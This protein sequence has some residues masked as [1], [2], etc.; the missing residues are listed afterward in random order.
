MSADDL[1][2]FPSGGGDI[3]AHPGSRL[4]FI[5]VLMNR[6]QW[7][8]WTTSEAR[9]EEAIQLWRPW[10]LESV[11][12]WWSWASHVEKWCKVAIERDYWESKWWGAVKE[13]KE[14]ETERE[15][16]TNRR[17]TAVWTISPSTKYLHEKAKEMTLATGTSWMQFIWDPEFFSWPFNPQICEHNEWLPLFY[18]TVLDGL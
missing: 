14:K 17:S 7:W 12:I 3:R 6:M 16:E 5:T 10:I 13:G 18:T 1:T 9:L 15:T 11:I 4:D 8:H 2:V